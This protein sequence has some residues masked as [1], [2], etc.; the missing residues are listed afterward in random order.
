MN[1]PSQSTITT[2]ELDT[3]TL[4]GNTYTTSGTYTQVLTNAQGCDSTITLI[5]TMEYTGLADGYR[6]SMNVYPNPTN[7]ELFILVPNEW[8]DQT[9]KLTDISGK[10]IARISLNDALTKLSLVDLA[11]GTYFIAV[12]AE[13]CGVIR[14]VKE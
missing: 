8:I 11:S 4:N 2:T 12:E 7:G 13:G 3:Y 1:N 9:A 10:V 5:L 6:S 14:V